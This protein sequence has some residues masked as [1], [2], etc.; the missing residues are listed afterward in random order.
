MADRLRAAAATQTAP[1]ASVVRPPP[2]AVEDMCTHKMQDSL[3]R[4]L[5]AA[6]DAH[7]KRALASLQEQVRRRQNT[8]GP[9]TAGRGTACTRRRAAPL[10][11]AKQMRRSSPPDSITSD[12]QLRNQ[13]S[14]F[15]SN[16]SHF[17][18]PSGATGPCVL[19][20][21]RRG[22]VAGLLR[23]D[24]DRALHLPVPRPHLCHQPAGA[25]L[26]LRHGPAAA[27]RAPGED[28]AGGR[29]AAGKA[30]VC[31]GLWLGTALLA[32][33]MGT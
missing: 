29:P 25:A 1:A 19:P 31:G 5:Q 26:H 12:C 4:R 7:I 28:A 24:A 21:P 33:G 27:A 9:R 15:E 10:G 14:R 3:Y 18:C 17:G 2:Q 13:S 8:L 22:D 30:G 11:V 16:R 23:A 6:C 32:L 20:G